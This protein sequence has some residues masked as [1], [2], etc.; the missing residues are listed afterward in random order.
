M[1]ILEILDK[2]LD[3]SIGFLVKILLGTF[4]LYTVL[5]FVNVTD[6]LTDTLVELQLCDEKTA[7]ALLVMLCGIPNYVVF[8]R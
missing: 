2:V 7:K 6:A 5:V 4:A 3:S 1:A 8:R